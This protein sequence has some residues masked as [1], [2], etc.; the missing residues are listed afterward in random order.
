MSTSFCLVSLIRRCRESVETAAN[1][2]GYSDERKNGGRWSVHDERSRA[3]PVQR[4]Q[5]S[6]FP[7]CLPWF[8]QPPGSLLLLVRKLKFLHNIPGPDS[9]TRRADAYPATKRFSRHG[10][11]VCVQLVGTFLDA[12]V[13]SCLGPPDY[14]SLENSIKY[15]RPR[16]P[17][18]FPTV[19]TGDHTKSTRPAGPVIVI[20]DSSDDDANDVA[21]SSVS[22]NRVSSQ[23][24]GI[25]ATPSKKHSQ[26][27][28][29]T[30]PKSV[31]E[32]LKDTTYDQREPEFSDP[33][34][35]HLVLTG[36]L[37]FQNLAS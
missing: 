21:T 18:H 32:I 22:V 12:L 33:F 28:R 16:M 6:A 2:G 5:D 27:P 13:L 26:T 29:S 17:E 34:L 4:R 37:S 10:Q 19:R 35:S 14:P 23:V 36:N 7:R 1:D 31:L 9:P 3:R 20:N 25:T 30:I 8:L 24:Q 11:S 15:V